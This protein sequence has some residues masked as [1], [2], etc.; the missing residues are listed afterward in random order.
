MPEPT[1]RGLRIGDADPAAWD[2]AELVRDHVAELERSME[3][4]YALDPV[5]LVA[6]GAR[7]FAARDDG[8][9]L[10]GIAAIKPLAPGEG[11][12]KSMR[13]TD[14]ARGTGVGRALLR[15][16]VREARRAGWRV[17]RL[18]TGSE[19]Y[20][21]PARRLYRSE[22]F[23]PTGAF[24][25]YAPHPASVFMALDLGAW[26]DPEPR[27]DDRWRAYFDAVV[28]LE[29]D[30]RAFEVRAVEG[31]GTDGPFPYPPGTVVHFVTAYESALVDAGGAAGAAENR[32]RNARLIAEIEA[33][34]GRWSPAAGADPAW[35]HVE[36][37]P[38]VVGL[39]D[40]QVL[41]LAARWHQ[42]AVFRWTADDWS[43]IDCREG[44]VERRG[45]RSRALPSAPASLR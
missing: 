17:L 24:A 19:E 39:S 42:D 26:T 25:H 2:I 9:T 18:E 34:G 36:E 27:S 8:G 29:V 31:P 6:S 16:A 41:E 37:S 32:R 28:R 20:S 22:G 43:V 4:S 14:A 13:T 21:A 23:T 33:M 5:A 15:R 12:L 45:W 44:A 1:H 40:E 30:A 11:E 38:A 7:L 35:T 10:L 3:V